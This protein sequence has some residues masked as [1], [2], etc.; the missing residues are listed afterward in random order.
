MDVVP[1]EIIHMDENGA[2]KFPAAKLEQVVTN[3]R[4][5]KEDEDARIA[6]MLKAT[7]LAEM[8]AILGGKAYEG[9]KKK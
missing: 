3:L 2:V 8:K 6:K 5:F 7:S 9:E 1:G 4:A